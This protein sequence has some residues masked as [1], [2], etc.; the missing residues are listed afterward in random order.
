MHKERILPWQEKGRWYHFFVES[1]GTTAKLTTADITDT[2]ITNTQLT[3]P[4]DF[5]IVDVKYDV[6]A[7]TA[8]SSKTHSHSLILTAE[9]KQGISLPNVANYDY[10]NIYIFGYYK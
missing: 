8:A 10:A 1:T 5:H 7:I 6:N 3:M 9:G 4:D 2:H